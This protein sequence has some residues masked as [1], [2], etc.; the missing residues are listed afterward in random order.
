[1]T[2]R[3]LLATDR[4]FWRA[5]SGSCARIAS[6]C[7]HLSSKGRDLH[8]FF[9]EDLGPDDVTRL[10]TGFPRVTVHSAGAATEPPTTLLGRL[11]PRLRRV[12]RRVTAGP[13]RQAGASPKAAAGARSKPAA[14]AHSAGSPPASSGAES[15]LADFHSPNVARAFRGLCKRLRPDV[16]LVEYIRLSY[17]VQGLP[18]RRG[19]RPL[20]VLDTLDVMSERFRRFREAGEAHWLRV[21]PEEEGEVLKRFDVVLAIHERDAKRLEAMVP[22]TRV[23]TTPHGMRVRAHPEPTEGPVRLLHVATATRENLLAIEP[24]LDEVWPSLRE[25]FGGRTELLLA[26]RMC[27]RLRERPPEERVS[28]AGYVED[29]NALYAAAHIVVNPIRLGAGLKIKNVEA[30][31]H[32]KPL[33]TTPVGAEGIEEHGRGALV[34]CETSC[35][36]VE[37]LSRLIAT[38]SLRRALSGQ[39]LRLAEEVFSPEQAY[40]E[41]DATLEE[42]W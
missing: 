34:V 37:A 6:L 20:R 1:M 7:R 42:A 32:G 36:M 11:A 26:G 31:C 28:L 41:L 9:A 35:A 10:K 33:V 19:G 21:G 14:E 8:V 25:R 40:A 16:V 27:E 17:L 5:D 18:R 24:F 15:V 13:D 12:L 22:G 3:I 30:L 2:Q 29:R 4:R 39:A 38:P 23:V